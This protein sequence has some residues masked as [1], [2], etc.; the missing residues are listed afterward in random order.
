MEEEVGGSGNKKMKRRE[1]GGG[2]GRGQEK[3]EEHSVT[4]FFSRS[5]MVAGVGRW[6]HLSPSLPL[7]WSEVEKKNPDGAPDLPS[8]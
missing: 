1:S 5:Q 2:G 7:P 4:T 3:V 8:D 6:T